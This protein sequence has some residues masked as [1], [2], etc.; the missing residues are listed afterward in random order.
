[1]RVLRVFM[2]TAQEVQELQVHNTW[3]SRL[4]WEPRPCLQDTDRLHRWS[5]HL[6]GEQD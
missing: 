5:H 1:M 2:C 3:H 6:Q 4:S